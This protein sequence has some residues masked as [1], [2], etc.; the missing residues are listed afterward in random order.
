VARVQGFSINRSPAVT[1]TGM[2][3]SDWAGTDIGAISTSAT[4]IAVSLLMRGGIDPTGAAGNEVRGLVKPGGEVYGPAGPGGIHMATLTGTCFCGDVEIR[5]SGEPVGMGYCHCSDCRS[6]SAGPVNA[7][8][9]W[10]PEDVEVV[11]GKELLATFSKSANSQRQFCSRCGGHLMTVH[12]VWGLI[13]VFV[14]TIPGLAF[15]PGVHVNYVETVLPMRDG[16]PKLK[17]FPVALGG[18]G[19]A[20]PE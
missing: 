6:W 19:E 3:P 17:G 1:F 16:L 13:D 7:F 9:L 5:V 8:S 15:K 14:A 11:R 2:S 12:P 20:V 18:T 4:R 10:K